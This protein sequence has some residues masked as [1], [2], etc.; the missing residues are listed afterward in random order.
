MI[1]RPE[2]TF[3]LCFRDQRIDCSCILAVHSCKASIV[4]QFLNDLIKI[5]VIY[6]H[7]RISH[8]QF[9][10]GDTLIDHILNFF[11]CFFVPFHDR[12]MERIVTGTFTVRFLMPFFQ[13][14]FQSMPALV[15]RSIINDQ[16]RTARDG[17][18]CSC[19][20]IICCDCPC[21][22]QVKMCMSVYKARKKELPADIDHL[23]IFLLQILPCLYNG[24]TIDQNIFSD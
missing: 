4:V 13:S 14:L 1:F 16:C 10:T 6:D 11:L 9:K 20:K 18:L 23:C 7:R 2:T 22:I 21:Y 24:L 15:L 5:T 8:I 19:L 3:F 12:H 17:R